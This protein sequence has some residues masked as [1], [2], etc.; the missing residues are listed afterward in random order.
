[1]TI[2]LD[3][4]RFTKRLEQVGV[5]REQAVAHAEH[6]RDMV[7]ADVSSKDDLGALKRDIDAS[8]AS[9]NSG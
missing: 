6:A 9:W 8:S 4:L 2:A 7:L 1:M 3:T 5:T